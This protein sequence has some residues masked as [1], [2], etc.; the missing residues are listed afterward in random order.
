MLLCW[1]LTQH[2]FLITIGCIATVCWLI[3]QLV[4]YFSSDD[5]HIPFQ[6]P[7]IQDLTGLLTCLLQDYLLLPASHL[8]P[9][10]LLLL[11]HLWILLLPLHFLLFLLIMLL[12]MHVQL[13]YLVLLF[14]HLLFQLLI[15]ILCLFL[16]SPPKL[17]WLTLP[18]FQKNTTNSRMCSSRSKLET[19]HHT[20]LMISRLIWRKTPNCLL[21][22]CICFQNTN[23][24]R[25]GHF[26]MK[27]SEPT[28]ST[29]PALLTELLFSS[30]RQ[31]TAPSASW[32]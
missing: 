16:A 27:T 29:C 14:L 30:S 20:I 18:T 19:W 32:L 21:E 1:I 4:N 25:Y 28:L 10:L 9:L 23:W 3:G 12:L 8:F 24:R 11:F 2:S 15:P 13:A 17:N 22:E 31:R 26:W 5:S 6:C 7:L